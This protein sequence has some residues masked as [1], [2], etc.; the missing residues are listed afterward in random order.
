MRER[1]LELRFDDQRLVAHRPVAQEI[2][3]RLCKA[4]NPASYYEDRIAEEYP[5]AQPTG[6][7]DTGSGAQ[8][9]KDLFGN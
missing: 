8:S 6:K 1:Q 4:P 9:L 2:F 5:S 3:E 7:R